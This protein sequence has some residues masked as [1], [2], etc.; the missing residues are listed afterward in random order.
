[1]DEGLRAPFLQAP[2]YDAGAGGRRAQTGIRVG[3]G[4]RQP[5]N[6]GRHKTRPY[7]CA[8]PGADRVFG[9]GHR[10]LGVNVGVFAGEKETEDG[11]E[12]KTVVA[13]G[14][15][16]AGDLFRASIGGRQ[17]AVARV[18]VGLVAVEA[19]DQYCEFQVDQLE[20]AVRL[21]DQVIW[22]EI[23]HD[24]AALVHEG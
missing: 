17:G 12:R 1:M 15:G 5:A 2:Q 14:R 16:E 10:A 7:A 13:E 24:Y 3:E 18:T 8:Q 23:P 21:N 11:T 19:I 20:L 9:L 22:S 6:T 4:Q